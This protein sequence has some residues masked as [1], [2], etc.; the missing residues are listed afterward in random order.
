MPL[1]FESLSHGTIAFGFFNIDSDMLLLDQY[2]F[3]T[4][5]FCRNIEKIAGFSK[6]QACED[7]WQ[8]YRIADPQ[9]I[10]DLHS[11]IR[12][13]R[14]TGFIGEV[15]RRFPFPDK[16]VLFKQ[17]PDGRRNRSIVE[18]INQEVAQKIEITVYVAAGNQEI[19]IG[20][21]RFSRTVFHELINYVWRGGFPRWQDEIRPQS[22]LSMK[23]AITGDASGIFAGIYLGD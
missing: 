11:A 23:K 22:V 13:V 20:V 21:Y 3:F 7:I 18:D 8:V 5:D 2:F 4:D 17:K 12:G 16:K 15:Y 6:D 1:A 19:H 14:H 10:G 9:Q